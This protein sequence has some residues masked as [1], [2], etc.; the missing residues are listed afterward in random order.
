MKYL[1][2]G[3]SGID[4][5]VIGQGTWQMGDDF[6]GD[7]DENIAI[8]TIKASI[9]AGVTM[10]DTAACYGPNGDAERVVG[11]GLKGLRDKVVLASKVGVLRVDGAYVRCLDPNVMRKELERSLTR[12]ATDYIDLYYIHWPDLNN[13][14]DD[15]L[16]MMVRFKEEGK[17][18]AIGVSNFDVSQIEK[19]VEI[20]DICAV[21]PPFSL[22]D[23][24]FI[25]NGVIPYCE[26]NNICAITYGSLG[27]GILSGKTQK[28]EIAGKELRASFYSHYQEPLWSKS[29]KFLDVLREIAREKNRTVAQISI[30]WALYQSGVSCALIGASSPQKAYD[31]A[32]TA[33]FELTSEE[34]EMIN[35]QYS[36]VFGD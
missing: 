22:F 20:A 8:D 11:K 18:R 1:K 36:E 6:F 3:N 16:E 4:I 30:N 24:R 32:G 26:K 17:I 34:I 7:I 9:D 27:G 25:E 2:M 13:S 15:A 5:S 33:D 29:Q 23:R 35:G 28:P 14:M 12:L 21:Q 31:N 19:A 10:I